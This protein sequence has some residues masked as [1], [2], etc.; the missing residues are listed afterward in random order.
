MKNFSIVIPA[1]NEEV[2]L[3]K[4]LLDLINKLK[5]EFP[6]NTY[7]ILL[8]ENGSQ[9]KTLTIAKDLSSKF[10]FL[11]VFHLPKPSY[12]GALRKGAL[13]AKNENL[14]IFNVDFWDVSFLKKALKLLEN[15]D[16]VIGSKTLIASQDLRPFHR[17]FLTY[18]FNMLLKIL[19]N[20]PGS[21]THGIKVL[22]KKKFLPLVKKCQSSHELFDTELILRASKKG[23]ILTELPIRV[24]EIR[25]TRYNNLKRAVNTLKDLILIFRAKL[26]NEK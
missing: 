14:V 10:K 26:L 17:R 12:G 16:I 8:I 1:Y 11:Q 24:Q 13:E 5:I 2:V 25:P 23:L 20:F 9:D 3:E 6:P 19:F 22:K 18:S 7:E 21:D 15:A 4:S